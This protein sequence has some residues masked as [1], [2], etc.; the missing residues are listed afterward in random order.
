MA[1]W[2][3]SRP[4][5]ETLRIAVMGCVVNGP[6]ESRHAD[7]G[8]SLPGSGEDPRAPVFVDGKLATT[9]KGERIAEEFLRLLDEYVDERF[10]TGSPSGA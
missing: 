4:G 5:V 7:I 1:A 2:R 10:G 6:G 9:L 3:G 8:I